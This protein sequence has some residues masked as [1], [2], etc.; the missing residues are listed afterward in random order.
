MTT[1]QW[2]IPFYKKQFEW[3]NPNIELEMMDDTSSQV[4]EIEEQIGRPFETMLDIGAGTG[5]MARAL[6]ARGISMITLEI[7]PELCA[8]ARNNSPTT[9]DIHE[10][11]FYTYEFAK[12]FDVVSYFDGFEIGTD[13]EQLKL[14]KRIKGWLNS[15]GCGLIDIYQPNFWRKAAG[16]KMKI[17]NAERIYDYDEENHR[18]LDSWWSPDEPDHVVT[19]SLRCYTIC[20][21]SELCEN[22]GLQIVGIF[23]GGAMD[24]ENWVYLHCVPLSEC[25]S[26]RIK[27]RIAN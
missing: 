16:Q 5:I 10:G 7:V 17:D 11:D 1:D 15:G 18:M 19:Q 21:I 27:V 3:L 24:Y 25:W 2:V 9:I 4:D 8:Y 6:A 12:Q 13:L 20:E 26:Y 23:P 22:A 14:L